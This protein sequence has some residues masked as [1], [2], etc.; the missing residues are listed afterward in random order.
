MINL[1]GPVVP[2]EAFALTDTGATFVRVSRGE[3]PGVETLR[4]FDHAP[5]SFTLGSFGTP[6]FSADAFAPVVEAGRRAGGG[7]VRRAGVTFPD[8][9]ART[10][11]LDFD[12]LPPGRKERADMV[13]WKIKKLLPGKVDDL[14]VAFAEIPKGT[15]GG[16]RLLVSA[17]PRETLRSVETAFAS[18]G[19]RV[20]RLEPATL[21][22]FNGLDR[23][24]GEAARGDYL[25]LHRSRGATSLLIARSGQPLFYRQ[26]STAVDPVDDVQEIRLSLSYYAE[27]FGEAAPPP[28]LVLDESSPEGD[29][30]PALEALAATAVSADLL[31]VDASVALHARAHPEALAAAASAWESA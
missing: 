20:G 3:R 7:G 5:G 18:A 12:L 16:V 22:L 30:Y 28:V 27:S 21:A 24:L 19:V 11:T 10:M 25:F 17:S 4:Y 26:K 31:G 29:A 13:H 9:W 2:P 14:E 1:F 15:G 23:R 8:S 6:V